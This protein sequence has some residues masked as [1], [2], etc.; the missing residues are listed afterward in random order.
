MRMLMLTWLRSQ[1]E[2]RFSS[3][4]WM[5][6]C[7]HYSPQAAWPEP[8]K[9]LHPKGAC[10]VSRVPMTD[11]G[12]DSKL[13]VHVFVV[14]PRCFTPACADRLRL[15]TDRGRAHGWG[16]GMTPGNHSPAIWGGRSYYFY[17]FVVIVVIFMFNPLYI[18]QQLIR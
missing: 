11:N 10:V 1:K 9:R 13:L 6:R 8:R 3:P 17:C 2:F 18:F 7:M 4:K 16:E 12:V 14:L 5:R 15:P